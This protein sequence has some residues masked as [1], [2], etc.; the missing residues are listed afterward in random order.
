MPEPKVEAWLATQNPAGIYLTAVSEAELRYG[1]TIIAHSSE[2]DHQFH[3]DSDHR[4]HGY[5]ITSRSE[6]TRVSH[7]G[8]K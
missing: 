8:V 5:P 1:A 3:C 6:A 4:F 7:Y 2:S